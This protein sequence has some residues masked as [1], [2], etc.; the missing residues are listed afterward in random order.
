MTAVSTQKAETTIR[1]TGHPPPAVQIAGQRRSSTGMTVGANAHRL[2]AGWR[3]GNVM[4]RPVPKRAEAEAETALFLRGSDPVAEAQALI[5]LFQQLGDQR[6]VLPKCT[7]IGAM[8]VGADRPKIGS[9]VYNRM[10]AMAA[11]QQIAWCYGSVAPHR[12]EMVVR[13]L[14][15]GLELRTAFAPAS[16]KVPV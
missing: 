10:R 5:T 15:T 12:G 16:W 3:G 11:D 14:A 7:E 1:Y 2:P 4:P 9:I 6:Q 8:L 13:V